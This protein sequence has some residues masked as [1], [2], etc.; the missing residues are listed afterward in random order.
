[1]DPQPFIDRFGADAV[2]LWCPFLGPV[3][4]D[5]EWHE[6]GMEGMGRFLHRLW[7]V[8][9]ESADAPRAESDVSTDLG[10]LR[11]VDTVVSD[12]YVMDGDELRKA[13]GFLGKPRN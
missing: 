9:L 5:A 1:M 13:A 11:R 10:A 12:G 8:A 6:D 7:R 4:Q 3:D 2:R